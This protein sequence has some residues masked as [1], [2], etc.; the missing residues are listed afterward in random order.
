MPETVAIPLGS[1]RFALVD[2]EDYPKVRDHK[3]RFAVAR[4]ATASRGDETILMHRLIMDAPPGSEIDHAD[5]NGLNNRRAN[6]RFCTRS[7]N[8]CNR[9][10]AKANKL[11]LKG[12]YMR[13][14]SYIARI[15][16]NGK[17]RELGWFKT[18]E[19]AHLAYR[20]AAIRHH[21]KFANYT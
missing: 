21:G 20:I 19:E 12:V 10:K 18:P 4:Y 11:G 6:L 13:G 9:S 2:A 17:C 5:G 3:W 14:N 7:Q 1:G 8:T 15:T 16:K